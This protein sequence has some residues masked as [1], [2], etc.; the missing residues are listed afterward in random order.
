M[1]VSGHCLRALAF[2][3]AKA[4]CEMSFQLCLIRDKYS[5]AAFLSALLCALMLSLFYFP[6]FY[7]GVA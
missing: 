4:A 5:V 1:A 2:T 7:A 6:H 3:D